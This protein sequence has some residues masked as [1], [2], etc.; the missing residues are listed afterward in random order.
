VKQVRQHLRDGALDIGEVP[1]P[2]VGPDDVLVR[3]RYSFVS[4]GTERMKVS[5]ARMSLAAKAKQRPDQV[6]QVLDTVR[7]QGLT[8]TVR[9][10]QERLKAPSTLGYSC[11]GVV[12]AVGSH[13]DEFR[14]GDLVAAIGEGVATHA[15]YNG[16]PR[17]LVAQVPANVSL[18]DASASAIGAIAIHSLRQAKLELGESVA[19]VGLGLLGQ[20]LVQLCRATGCRVMGIDLDVGK[21]ELAVQS[22]AEAACKPDT[23]DALHHALEISGGLGVDAVL[24][25]VSTKDLGPIDLAAALVRDRGRV[26]C[27]G[28]TAIQLDWRTWFGKEIDFRFSRAMGAGIYDPDYFYRGRD[29]PIGYV[30]WTA[31]R[32]VQAFLDLIEQK[33]LDL[34]KLITHRFPFTDAMEVFDQ[35]AN[36]AMSKAVGIVFEYA[37]PEHGAFQSQPRVLTFTGERPT[38]VVRLGQIGAGNYAKSMLMPHF[39]ELAG[40]SLLGICTTKGANSEDLARRYHFRRATTDADALLH[41]PDINA[42]LVAT[43]HDSHARYAAAALRAGKHVYVEKPLALNDEQLDPVIGA[44]TGRGESG[45]TLWVGYNRRFSPLTQQALAHFAGTTVR[46]VA[47]T[48]RSTGVPADS[49]Y[50]DP[51]EGGGILFGDVCHF[52]DLC[53][54]LQDSLPT[55]V[56]AFATPDPGHRGESW[57]ITMR[58]ANGGLGVVHYVCGNQ[59]G[60]HR[61]TVDI[62]GGSRSARI[63]GFR[64]LILDGSR[65]GGKQLLQPHM[66]QKPMLETMV[67]QF[68]RTAGARD[69]TE[70]FLVSAQAL[71]A[72]RRSIAERRTVTMEPRFPF[73]IG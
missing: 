9:K 71:L 53:I 21:C 24:L 18:E 55:D 73:T 54:W 61:E 30:R 67:A 60:T 42:I 37:E 27:L 56:S 4:V 12:E 33:K 17:N 26:V 32:N 28:N 29:Y 23:D 36:G 16:V 44:L 52:I 39:P 6:R 25:T 66:G 68:S 45:P 58:F 7:E 57:A 64:R 47:C 65:R 15:E 59:K 50:H 72:A 40:L 20:F 69:Y 31:N 13:V 46:Q 48:I 5:Q 10:V 1:I 70:S 2:A 11:S 35:I 62:V 49:W 14:V 22:G 38:G 51:T 3:T 63:T 8:P 43:R 34:S 41:D 19:I